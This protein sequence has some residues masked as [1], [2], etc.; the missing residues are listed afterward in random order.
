[1][2]KEWKKVNDYEVKAICP[3]QTPTS[4]ALGTFHFKILQEGTPTSSTAGGTGPYK[5]KEFNLVSAPS[6]SAS[7]ITG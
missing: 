3:R 1:M 5:V 7:T 4:I 2:V 6:V